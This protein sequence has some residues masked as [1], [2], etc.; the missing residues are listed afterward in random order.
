MRPVVS[1]N[2]IACPV[3]GRNVD[4]GRNFFRPNG[5][6]YEELLTQVIDQPPV[7][8]REVGQQSRRLGVWSLHHLHLRSQRVGSF[9]RG[10][11]ARSKAMASVEQWDTT[12]STMPRIPGMPSD[13]VARARY[14][15][16]GRRY[17][18][19]PA[20]R[21]SHRRSCTIGSAAASMIKVNAH[22]LMPRYPRRVSR[23]SSRSNPV[24]SPRR[25]SKILR[26]TSSR[27]PTSG[28]R[29]A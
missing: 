3:S 11:G 26:A 8:A 23:R 4:S 6:V 7:H 9:W 22:L 12:A 13:A 18:T 29:S 25:L 24:E 10:T 28:S 15:A 27:A 17:S 2:W 19:M 21:N 1:E 14:R 16:L 20:H 5:R